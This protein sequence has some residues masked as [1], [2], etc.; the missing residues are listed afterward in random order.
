MRNVRIVAPDEFDN[1]DDDCDLW[2]FDC[3]ECEY[4][5][6]ENLNFMFNVGDSLDPCAFLLAQPIGSLPNGDGAIDNDDLD[7]D[8]YAFPF[9]QD[10]V[11]MFPPYLLQEDGVIIPNLPDADDDDAVYLRSVTN[12]MYVLAAALANGGHAVFPN[13]RRLMPSFGQVPED[14]IVTCRVTDGIG[15]DKET[16]PISVVNY[17]VT[18]FPP[19]LNDLDDQVFYVNETPDADEGVNTYRVMATDHDLQDMFNL[20]YNCTLN[21]LP[22]YQVGPFQQRIIHPTSGLIAFTP[23]S[24]GALQAVITVEDPRGMFSVGEITIFCCNRGTW[25]NHPP[26]ILGDM[27]SP[28]T[29]RAGQLFIANEMDFVDPDGDELYWSCNIGAVGENGI[30]TF[31]SQ[32]PGYYLVQITAYDIRG[33]AATTEFLIHVMPWWSY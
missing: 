3:G 20:T 22:N 32:Y 12:P 25:F 18:N 23:Y 33:G 31:Q 5:E 4:I 15:T 10:Q 27:D 11:N 28:Q 19:M 13:V 9:E 6:G 16:F 29:I 21:G 17:P 1:D 2:Q 24:E 7:T 8:N 26:I 14:L 30:Y